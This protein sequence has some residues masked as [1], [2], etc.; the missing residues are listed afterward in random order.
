MDTKTYPA[1]QWVGEDFLQRNLPAGRGQRFVIL[2]CGIENGFIENCSLVFQS[3]ANDGRDYH[4]EMNSR[5]L[6]TWIEE[7][8]IPNL[9]ED[10]VVVI[11]MDNASNHSTLIEG[12]K[13]PTSGSRKD[14]IKK[15]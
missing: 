13:A 10:S 9:P 12:S 4:S 8:L 11:I 1:R 2:H 5:I 15:F 6:K 14:E 3:K 7:Q